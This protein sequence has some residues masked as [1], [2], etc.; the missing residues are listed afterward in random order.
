M[1]AA[2]FSDRKRGLPAARIAAKFHL[3]LAG[4]ASD[5]AVR[6]RR[7]AGVET[8]VLCGGVFL[9]RILLQ[10]A[11]RTL[12]EKGFRVLRPIA[13]SPNDEAI[14]LGQIAFALARRRTEAVSRSG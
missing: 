5:V 12:E 1:T 11:T 6:A 10:A 8:A 7:E 14:S 4:L 2:I 3:S 9:N 13:Y